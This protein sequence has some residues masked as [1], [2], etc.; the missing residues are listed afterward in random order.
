MT[1]F[2]GY[3]IATVLVNKVH[4]TLG[5]RGIA[6][7]A[8]LCHLIPFLVMATHPPYPVILAAYVFV[9][10]GN[11]LIDAAWN[12]WVADMVN[13]NILMGFLSAFYGLGA[14]VSPAIAT[15]M[16]HSGLR[17]NLYYYTMVGGAALEL[18]LSTAMFWG[19]DAEKFRLNNPKTTRNAGSSRTVHAMKQYVTWL[20]AVWLFIYMGVEG[21]SHQPNYDQH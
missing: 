6:I 19:E 13:P 12:A 18:V 17:W 15:A 9:G 2:A 1:P 20:I 16:I 7:I 11:G 10:L 5:Q 4:M 3:T 21:G 8:P 14:T